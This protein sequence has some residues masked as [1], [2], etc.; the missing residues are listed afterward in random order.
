MSAFERYTLTL[1]VITFAFLTFTFALLVIR[2]VKN[3]LRMI[4]GGLLDKEIRE[5]RLQKEAKRKNKAVRIIFDYCLPSLVLIVLLS[6]F[7]FSSVT[8]CD[9]TKVVGDVPQT[10]VVESGSMEYKYEGNEYL[11]KN[12]LNDQIGRFDLVFIEKLPEESELKL[13]DVV[14]YE[15]EGNL[16]I[17]RIVKID[18]NKD[19]VR[20]F[21][22]QGDANRYSDGKPVSYSQMRGIYRGKRIR[23][24]GSFVSFMRSPAGYLCL[25]LVVAVFAVYPFLERRIA[26]EEEKRIP[27]DE[28][29]ISE[30]CGADTCSDSENA[31]NDENEN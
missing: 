20:S 15:Y 7:V 17:H 13:Y 18:E 9:G 26:K 14:V 3:T 25:F 29:P 1:C 10:K 5:K 22:L 4:N 6:L 21:T 30:Q 16:I 19:G 27:L 2:D 23:F 24:V 31:E 28:E 12:E 8:A 11:F